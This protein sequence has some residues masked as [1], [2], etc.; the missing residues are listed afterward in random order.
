MAATIAASTRMPMNGHSGA[1][2]STHYKTQNNHQ[3][4][5]VSFGKAD[6]TQIHKCPSLSPR[7]SKAQSQCSEVLWYPGLD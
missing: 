4:P 7:Y 6:E 5:D 3:W 1:S 2:G